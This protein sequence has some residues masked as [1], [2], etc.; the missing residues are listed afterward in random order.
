MTL[1]TGSRLGP[2][3]ILS[4]LGAGGMGEVYRARD[5]T[6]GRDVAL[7]FLPGEFTHDPE[8][9]ARFRREAQVLASLNHPHIGGIYGL[10]EANGLT[11]LVLELVEGP[12][13]A[14]RIAQGAVPLDE[15]LPIAKQ[16]AEALESAHEHGI[17]HR[18]LKPAN[19]K[20]RDDGT[21]KVLDFG[22]AKAM[23]PAGATSAGMSMFPAITTPAMTQAGMILGTAAY[24]SPEQARGRAVD[25]R[26]DVWAF[27]CVFF[28]MLS[29]R[30]AFDGEDVTDTIA[31]V[32]RSEPKW[33]AL[34]PD[35]PEQIRLLLKRCL[36]KDRKVRISDVGVARFLM[37]ETMP[38]TAAAGVPAAPS[39]A[40]P[41]RPL[42]KRAAPL[43]AA[44]VVA[45]IVGAAAWT[46][47]PPPPATPLVVSRFSIPLGEGQSFSAN[48]GLSVAISPDGSKLVYIAN[49]QLY[50]RLLSELQATPIPGTQAERG[51]PSVLVFSP[52]GQSVAFFSGVNGVI[53][54]IA[55]TGGAPITICPATTPPLGMS[56]NAGAIVFG[57]TSKGIV[58]VS[59]SGGQPTVIASV[60]NGEVPYG[61][62]VLPGGDWVLFTLA[63]SATT[64]GWDKAQIVVQS[65]KTAERRTLITGG[66]DGRYLPTGHLVYALG[67]VLFAVPFDPRT[68]G[69]TGVAVSMVEGVK[70]SSTGT[71]GTTHL[72][73]SRT[74]SLVFVPGP[75]STSS[76]RTDLG[77]FARD[78]TVQPLKLPP[79]RYEYPR[80]SPNG[81]QIVVGTDDGKD[82]GVWIYDV[83]GA[84]SIRPL[85]V[86]GRNRVPIWSSDGERV[87]FQSD[88]DGDLAIF[89][90]R[91][92]GTA[93]AE[94][95]TKPDNDTAHVP[96]SWSPDGKTLLFSVA[97][98]ST[99]TVAALSLPEKKVIAVAG[100]ESAQPPSA[101]FSP[102]GRWVAYSVATPGAPVGSLNV[103]PFPATGVPYQIAKVGL[104][105]TWTRDGKELL[106]SPAPNQLVAVSV[107]TRPPFTFGNPVPF[108]ARF[109][110]R[111][112]LYERNNDITLAGQQLLGV[113]PVGQ[114]DPSGKSAMQQMQ[115]VLNW[116]EELKAKVPT[117]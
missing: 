84:T 42:W 33:D 44:A 96:E 43:S 104:H 99:Y 101:A 20:V 65:L 100:I 56:W 36:E 72:S 95:L 106:Y 81:K 79:A 53:Q 25:K 76:G 10:E 11:A 13:L 77:L 74:G 102:D 12:T 16:I 89:W 88:R 90:Q 24:M 22:L 52:D 19:I 1:A 105:A 63:S 45:A 111:G 110:E 32:V 109:V 87:A 86:G 117:K 92:D 64:D 40:S 2:Y 47:K 57:Q 29:G 7:K 34:P 93:P 71:L 83:S 35:V 59:E 85:T 114:A 37:T 75:I 108:Q 8:R 4:A 50:L 60:K 58:R 31:A 51:T 54:K 26:S 80:L 9:V 55:V 21:V 115:V 107:T 15:A 69:V 27:G 28:E 18:D 112:P 113:A 5:T 6:L 23:E 68:L 61:P 97:K 17:I 14:D 3:E 103:Q 39:A 70:R 78:G 73:I 82:A 38:A 41:P 98:A 62:Q 91:A 30:C 94:R 67:G 116:F 46:L 66:S 48:S 49:N